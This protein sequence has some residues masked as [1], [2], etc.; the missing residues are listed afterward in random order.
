[1][2]IVKELKDEQSLITLVLAGLIG[3]ALV[4]AEFFI[5]LVAPIAFPNTKFDPTFVAGIHTL[6]IGYGGAVGFFL[7]QRFYAKPPPA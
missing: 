5:G 6:F 1:M 7:F 4:S 2:A 3:F